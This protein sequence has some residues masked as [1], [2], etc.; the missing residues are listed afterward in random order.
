MSFAYTPYDG[1]KQPFAIG[2]TPMDPADWIAPDAHLARDL[3]EKDA[4]L[5]QRREIVFAEEPD[6]RPAQAETLALLVPHLL[7]RFP[8]IYAREGDGVRVGGRTVPL[9]GEAPLVVASRLV[10]EDLVIMARGPAGWRLAAAS[11][12]FPSTWSL[13]EKFGREMAAIHAEVPGF[14]GRMGEI[15]ARIFDNLRP[16]QPVERLNWSIYGDDRLHHPESKSDPHERFPPAAPVLARATIRVERQ[17]LTRLHGAG[18]ILFTIRVF[19]D[20]LAALS[21]HP[22]GPALAGGLRDQLLA[23]TPDQLAYKGLVEARERLA[24]ALA[25]LASR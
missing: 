4:L 21:T 13:A 17:T 9:A 14:P 25:A 3:A 18:A 6:S 7:A 19:V 8:E 2:M 15:V 10:Q 11:L 1:S 24:G 22:R 23:L 16:G 12:C 20:P 5:A